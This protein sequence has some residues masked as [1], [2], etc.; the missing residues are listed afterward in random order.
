MTVLITGG[1]GYIGSH[2]TIQLLTQTVYDII[3]LDNLSTGHADTINTL[4]KIRTFKFYKI[5]LKEKN[6]IEKIFKKHR[7]H[8]IFH[9]A[10]STDVAES[11]DNPLKYYFNNTINTANL[12]QLSLQYEVEK[13]IFS[14]TAA[15][16][17]ESNFTALKENSA[18]LP[19]N[20][21]GNSK[22]MSEKIIIDGAKKSSLK[23]II[24]RYFNV[25]GADMNP[26]KNVLTPRI[27]ERHNPET[28]LIPLLIKTA[29]KKRELFYLYGNNYAT[30]DGTCIRDFI[31]VED[32]ASLHIKAIKYLD[33]HSSDI[34]NAGYGKGYS[35]KEVIECVKK[36][37]KSDFKISV[38]QKRE[39]DPK[40]LIANCN[41]LKSKINWI[42]KYNDLELICQSAYIWEKSCD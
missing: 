25:A 29:L 30:K 10:A 42:P 26:Y 32:L 19:L 15:V 38:V 35:I 36:L 12:V 7:I 39:G 33:N 23:Y 8:T 41:K 9:F 11:I 17:G 6:D 2:V 22:L 20:P 28:H 4:Q 1:A 18:T 37:T 16:Y 27:G 14:S 34:F 3:V 24:F 40:I 5:D 31:H 21:Y 13:F